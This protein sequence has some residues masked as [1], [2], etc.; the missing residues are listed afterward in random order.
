MIDDAARADVLIGSL[1]LRPHPE[2][3]HF[4]EVHRSAAAVDPLD[5]RS[6][7]PAGTAIY[8]LLRRGEVSRWH[9]VRSD[10]TWHFY[11]GSPLELWTMAH[12]GAE[13][14]RHLL[15]ALGDGSEPVCTVPAGE[16]QAARPLGAYALVGCTVAPGFDFEDF[17]MVRDGDLRFQPLEPFTD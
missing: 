5:G 9:R 3:G 15:G 8:F 7:R 12:E 6:R 17:E 16:W 4:R 1:G 14:R 11:E 10:E 2:G 13:P